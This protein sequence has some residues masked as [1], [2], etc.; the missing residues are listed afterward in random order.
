MSPPYAN[1]LEKARALGRGGKLGA[2][3]KAYKAALG[4]RSDPLIIMEFAILEAQQGFPANAH[5]LLLKAEKLAPKNPDVYVN[6]GEIF[7]M[8]NRFSEAAEQFEKACALTGFSDADAL[9]L[10][11]ETKRN[12]G[13]LD[14]AAIHI[15]KAA[16]LAPKDPAIAGAQALI[17]FSMGETAKA[18]ECARHALKLDPSNFL[19]AINLA[20][21]F[22]SLE[23][24]E[25]AATEFR[26]ASRLGSMTAKNV[27]D[28]A[29]S[30][31]FTERGE[32]ALE[33]ANT[34]QQSGADPAIAHLVSGNVFVSLGEFKQAAEHYRASLELKPDNAGA[35]EKL[36]LTRQLKAEDELALRQ[37]AEK[38]ELPEKRAKANFALYSVLKSKSPAEA[39]QAL[40]QAN[41]IYFEAKPFNA[42]HHF[43][44][45][46]KLARVFSKEFMASKKGQGDPRNGPIFIVGMPRSG[47]TLVETILAAYPEVYSGGERNMM[48]QFINTLPG[49]PESI[50]GKDA[51]WAAE[52]GR[53]LYDDMFSKAE[54]A[55]FVTDKL[56]GNYAN[57]GLIGWLM[58]NA[59]FIYCKREPMDNCLSC[60]EQNFRSGLRYAYD[61][62]SLGEA[63]RAHQQI[64]DHWVENSPHSIH[65]VEYEKLVNEPEAHARAFIEFCGL[66]FDK[67]CV[68]PEKVERS[69]S[70]ASAWQARQ[71]ISTGSVGKWKRYENELGPLRASL[72]GT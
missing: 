40:K 63:Y 69:I 23:R 50:A 51:G 57:I 72:E 61:L 27:S 32:E 26:N 9:Y 38:A 31:I 36:G 56:P 59:K 71:P 45:M 29:D 53:L 25:E 1:P 33:L 44:T 52:N 12:T 49:F 67:K 48:L 55:K 13:E 14:E 10:L 54:D 68:N 43:E 22:Y 8:E 30:L 6:L 21:L 39:F 34:L 28:W 4:K 46:D 5:K 47:T 7:R 60:Y 70:T 66:K 64:I 41:E 65:I 19:N 16:E 24:W 15:S 58:P 11:A 37:I 3:R 42:A 2:A 18:I 62:K 35:Y 20:G 17:C